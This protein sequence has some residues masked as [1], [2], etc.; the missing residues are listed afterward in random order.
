MHATDEVQVSFGH[1]PL[2][3]AGE[4]VFEDF[5][6]PEPPTGFG[7]T[8]E[9]EEFERLDGLIKYLCARQPYKPNYRERQSAGVLALAC[10]EVAA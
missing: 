7:E 6:E 5:P 2:D 3:Q 4:A 10:L 8:D 9:A 1:Q